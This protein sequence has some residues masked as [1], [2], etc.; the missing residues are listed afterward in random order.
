ML[1]KKEL[2]S[3]VTQAAIDLE[4]MSSK[5]DYN[6]S[7]FTL[8]TKIIGNANYINEHCAIRDYI[9]LGFSMQDLDEMGIVFKS[10]YKPSDSYEFEDDNGTYYNWGGQQLRNPMEYSPYSEGYTPFGDE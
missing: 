6:Q 8:A 7:D 2:R 3:L 9:E 10:Y 5:G 4:W 1:N